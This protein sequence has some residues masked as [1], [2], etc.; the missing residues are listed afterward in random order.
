M[1]PIDTTTGGLAAIIRRQVT[2]LARAPGNAS[3]R[4]SARSPTGRAD[5]PAEREPASDIAAL[6][7][8]RVQAIDPD[9]PNRQR[10]AFKVFLE[11][12]L[13]AEFGD[14]LINDAGFHQLVDDVHSEMEADD[15]LASAIRAATARLLAPST[16]S[17]LPLQR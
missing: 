5:A 9:D 14:G 11:S 13:L 17:T 6:I 1:N 4:G 16:G 3:A 10:K 12:V 7:A 8:R 2:S 15:E